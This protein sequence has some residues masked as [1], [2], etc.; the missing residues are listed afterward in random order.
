MPSLRL[1]NHWPWGCA[2]T[3]TDLPPVTGLANNYWL[4]SDL[5]DAMKWYYRVRRWEFRVQFMIG[6]VLEG[7]ELEGTY[8]HAGDETAVVCGRDGVD[9]FIIGTSYDVL[10]FYRG[11]ARIQ[12]FAPQLGAIRPG[13]PS[14]EPLLK[15]EHSVLQDGNTYKTFCRITAAIDSPTGGFTISDTQAAAPASQTLTVN[16]DGTVARTATATFLGGLYVIAEMRPAAFY[17]FD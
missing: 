11:I 1:L 8:T 14:P 7:A 17:A 2:R 6:D 3:L 5:A 15:N 12:L 4:S 16:F 10:G 9:I 13:G